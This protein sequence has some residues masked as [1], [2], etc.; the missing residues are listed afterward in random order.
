MEWQDR[1]WRLLANRGQN[2]VDEWSAGGMVVGGIEN[3]LSGGFNKGWKMWAGS[4]GLGGLAGVTG[5]LVYRHGV[6]GGKWD[7]EPAA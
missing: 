2:E 6:K 5:Y 7:E 3:L 4:L 1:S